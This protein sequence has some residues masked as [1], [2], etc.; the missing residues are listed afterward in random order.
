MANTLNM[1]GQKYVVVPVQA[2][3]THELDQ[4]QTTGMTANALGM[5]SG[6][7]GMSGMGQDEVRN[8]P[9]KEIMSHRDSLY[10]YINWE[11]P[12]HSIGSYLGLLGILVGAHY[13]PLTQLAL[14]LAATGLGAV[15]VTE[16]AGRA[17][18]DNTLVARLRPKEYRRLPESTLN[19]TLKDIHD[20]IQYAVVQ[21]QR[22]MFGQDLDKTFTALLGCTSLFWL[23][24]V[25][26]PFSMAILGLT[27][28]YIIP[29]M[30]SPRG[31]ELAYDARVHAG[32]LANTA[33]ESSMRLGKDGKE[34]LT[35]LSVS[36]RDAAL[37]A[38]RALGEKFQ[39][40]KRNTAETATNV[41][42]T[43]V[44]MA[45]GAAE[46]I[47]DKTQS[48]LNAA[49]NMSSN[50][51]EATMSTASSASK[52]I[53]DTVQSGTQRAF[54][55]TTGAKTATVNA[56]HS[57]AE[58]AKKMPTMGA[59]AVSNAAGK[60]SFALGGE[61]QTGSKNPFRTSGEFHDELHSDNYVLAHDKNATTDM[62]H[63]GA[64]D[65]PRTLLNQGV[66]NIPRPVESSMQQPVTHV[67]H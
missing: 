60:V 54:D 16:Y 39:S 2:D 24:K 56:S 21:A 40:G 8:G 50:A 7:T 27:S 23:L 63:T 26:S 65:S 51:K 67:S 37:D 62:R 12:V 45:K 48:G 17:F 58:T 18:G 3:G 5:S 47:G 11:D 25:M 38:K 42:D 30:T 41:K 49:G 46:T 29:L 20:F 9:L 1:S 13:L 10:K 35:R 57:T 52:N 66:T 14:K 22:I 34:K 19:A 53:G 36:G 32:E 64:Y 4:K 55:L 33:A 59:D 15:W 28:M 43:T 6:G 31:R 61:K 44:D